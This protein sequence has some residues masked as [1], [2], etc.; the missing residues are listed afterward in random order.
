MNEWMN[1]CQVARFSIKCECG[2]TA[3]HLEY[4]EKYLSPLYCSGCGQVV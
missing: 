1:T 3:G 2:S 4:G